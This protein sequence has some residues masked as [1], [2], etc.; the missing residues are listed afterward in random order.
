[1][2]FITPNFL[3]SQDTIKVEESSEYFSASNTWGSMEFNAKVKYSR[4]DI[5][6]SDNLKRIEYCFYYDNQ[7]NC[8]G[9][10]YELQ[11]D[12]T[13][14]IFESQDTLI[15]NFQYKNSDSLFIYGEN[16]NTYE[17][18]YVNSL[19]PLL[20][21]EIYT[22]NEHKTDTLW[23]SDFSNFSPE[24]PYS[25]PKW[26][27]PT[28]KINGK[29]YSSSEVDILPTTSNGQQLPSN[30]NLKRTK[31][32]I[33]EPLLFIQSMEFTIDNK[34]RIKNIKQKIGNFESN[35]CPYYLMEVMKIISNYGTLNPAK[36]NGEEVWM[37]Y[38][39]NV[40]M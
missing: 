28:N 22:L 27:Y 12:S 9:K 34:G 31:H 10:T 26:T 38:E 33:N 11:N 19:I 24:N 40:K 20:P 17:F 18:G 37:K 23:I 7:R 16:N 32:C 4:E 21:Y 15:Y 13:L 30:I 14:S 3:I 8:H 25:T 1:M 36:I 39:I 5:V 2:L 6:F 29:I 35:Y